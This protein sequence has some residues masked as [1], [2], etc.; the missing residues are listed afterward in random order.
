MLLNASKLIDTIK[1]YFGKSLIGLA[2]SGMPRSQARDICM[3]SVI[4]TQVFNLLIIREPGVMA[5]VGFAF[6][7]K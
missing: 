4:S 3:S 2:I 6:S 7:Q 5:P 1:Q